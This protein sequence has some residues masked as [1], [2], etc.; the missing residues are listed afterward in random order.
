MNTVVDF[1]TMKMCTVSDIS[2]LH[3]KDW[4]SMNSVDY[5]STKMSLS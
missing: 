4:I 1:F 3:V 2:I 5:G